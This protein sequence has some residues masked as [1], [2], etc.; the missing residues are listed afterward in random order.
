MKIYGSGLLLLFFILILS[1][2]DDEITNTQPKEEKE[3]IPPEIVE[4]E[5]VGNILTNKTEGI[6]DHLFLVN[7]AKNDRVYLMNK[8]A[9]IEFEWE[10]EHPIGNDCELLDNGQLL[11]ILQ[12]PEPKIPF[13]G[14]GGKIQLINPDFSID[15]EYNLSSVNEIAHHDVEMLPNGNVLMIV[16][17]KKTLEDAENAGYTGNSAIFP[18]SIYEYNP[19]SK[20]VVWRWNSWDHIIQDQDP[21]KENFGNISESPGKIDINY[22]IVEN[23]DIMH[24]NGISYDPYKDL[25]YLSVNFYSEVWV[26][27]HS[28]T[29]QEASTATG[30]NFGK[31]GDLVYRFGNPEAYKNTAGS[32][33]FHN[34]HYPNLIQNGEK[35]NMLLFMNG[36]NIQQ[37]SVFEF[38]LPDTFKLNSNNDNEPKLIWEFTREDLY[39]EKVS[40]AELLSNDNVLI[41]IGSSGAWEVNREGEVLWQFEGEGFYWRMYP[42]HINSQAIQNLNLDL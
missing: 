27:D 2:S 22:N 29:T 33:L 25:I 10:L 16:W 37:S 30:G 13:G 6:Q 15:W 19:N 36:N 8:K 14:Y 1:C 31:G 34:N 42:Y 9:E 23:G 32:R 18:E 20:E 3:E 38:E 41:S 26:I 17:I 21:E 7:D 28:T 4:K 11:A 12:A 5:I 40:G 35:T 39:S 24:A